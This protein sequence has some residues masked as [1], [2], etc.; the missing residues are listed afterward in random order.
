MDTE[1]Q[2]VSFHEGHK[3]PFETQ[4]YMLEH[5]FLAP[6]KGLGVQILVPFVAKDW[7]VSIFVMLV[8]DS[9]RHR[10]KYTKI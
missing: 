10:T 4:R 8:V 7:M 9:C 6:H 2:R 5:I 3:A 1:W